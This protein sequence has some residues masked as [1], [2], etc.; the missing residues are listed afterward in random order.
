MSRPLRRPRIS[1]VT[2][3]RGERP[4]DARVAV[5][6]PRIPARGLGRPL[7]YIQR[8]DAVFSSGISSVT[9]VS[10]APSRDRD[11]GHACNHAGDQPTHRL[12]HRL[13]VR[14]AQ[15]RTYMHSASTLQ[16][17]QH[18][19]QCQSHADNK[20]DDPPLRYVMRTLQSGHEARIPH[21]LP[22]THPG[23]PAKR[24][25]SRPQAPRGRRRRSARRAFTRRE[26]SRPRVRRASL[27]AA[28][29]DLDSVPLG[30]ARS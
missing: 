2:N 19:K 29:S 11:P 10:G 25:R 23:N 24:T 4:A 26:V 17:P 8:L 20:Q 5:A 27:R 22:A 21:L 13:A 6:R 18:P 14:H 16:E 1:S 12:R 9:E 30:P 7:R 15:N 3:R 28:D